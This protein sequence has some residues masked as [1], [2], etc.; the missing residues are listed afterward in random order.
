M[1]SLTFHGYIKQL[2][3]AVLLTFITGSFANQMGAA[4]SNPIRL[5]VGPF[6]AP[7]ANESLRQASQIIPELL[8]VDLSGLARFQL[9]ERQKIQTV[10]SELRLSA[11]ALVGREKVA[12]LGRVLA[13]DWLVSGSLVETPGQV[14]IWTKVIDVHNGVTLDLS[15][16]PYEPGTVSNVVAR[17]AAFVQN[18]RS[19]PEPRQFIAMGPFVDMNAPLGPKREDWSRRIPALIEKHFLDAGYGVTEMAAI[20]QIF[21]ERRLETTGLSSPDD[22]VKLQAAFWLVDG[23]CEWIEGPPLKLGVG[24]R[25]QRIGSPEE[26]FHLSEL[27]GGP[28]EK[29]VLDTLVLAMAKTNSTAPLAP[30]AEADLLAARGMELAMRNSPF[31]WKTPSAPTQYDAYKQLKVQDKKQADNRSAALAAY[32]RTLL[33][34][35]NNLEAKDMLGFALLGDPDPA[36][37]EHGKELLGEVIAANDRKY[38]DR[39][40]NHLTNAARI[41]QMV[42]RDALRSKRPDDWQSLNRAVEENPSDLEARCDL[43]AALLKLPQAANRER[44]RKMLAEVAAGDRPDQAER[45]RKLLS[46][47]EASPAITTPSAITTPVAAPSAPK[48]TANPLNEFLQKQFAKFIPV[49]FQK[50]GES[51]AL[52]QRLPVRNHLFEHEGHYYCGF[53]FTVPVWLD[54]NFEWM[55]LLAKAE[56]QKD[57]IAHN[58]SWYILPE[59]GTMAGFRY[60]NDSPMEKYPKLARHFPYTK[61]MTVQRLAKTSLKP[62]QQYA[63]WFEF[64]EKDPPDIA[65][66]MTIKSE[67]GANESGVLPLQ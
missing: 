9:V 58:M 50:D 61:E 45:A 66:A 8:T 4:E 18:A 21:E 47:P 17:I 52:I 63:I 19:K 38:R 37:R 51:Q 62:G 11:S 22:R 13:C 5:A 67:R 57:F 29:A 3:T 15:A 10:S 31:K 54:G 53:R 55:F 35:P 1:T 28:I 44:G 42:D 49:G 60:F 30:N 65:F 56:E 26:V 25:V 24:L 33:Q 34:D 12:N 46:E 27:P 59:Q 64:E 16:T 20:G 6:F 23:G 39:A 14:H 40:L 2:R 36:R 41:A 48:T 32:E 43:A 7:P